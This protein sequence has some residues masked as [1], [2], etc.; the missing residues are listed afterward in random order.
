MKKTVLILTACFLVTIELLAQSNRSIAK[1]YTSGK[2]NSAAL[3]I[4]VP[5]GEFAE[6]HFGGISLEYAWSH[7][8]FGNLKALPK[9]IPGFTANGSID[10]YFGKKETVAGNDYRYAGYIY[11]HVLGGAIYN[12]CKKINIALTAGPSVGIYKGNADA[13]LG[14][15]L[16]VN[17]FFTDKIAFS[18]GII[19]LK[20]NN[21][22]ALWVIGIRASY[23]F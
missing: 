20:H 16:S 4:N 22:A 12:P 2:S 3:G 18:P 23:S 19:F 14:V 11:L 21:A 6:T 5:V 7:H 9:R 17:Y 15:K 13:G 8:R 10:Y 1:N